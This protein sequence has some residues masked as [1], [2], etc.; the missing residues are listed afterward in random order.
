MSFISQQHNKA[1]SVFPFVPENAV[2][3]MGLQILYSIS[4]L[5]FACSKIPK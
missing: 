4:L 3:L 5:M 2:K 1:R